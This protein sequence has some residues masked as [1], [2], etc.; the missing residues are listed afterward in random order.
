M[1]DDLLSQ[2]STWTE[3]FKPKIFH[4]VNKPLV[5]ASPY[6]TILSLTPKEKELNLNAMITY[7]KPSTLQ[8]IRTNYKQISLNL[9]GNIGQSGPCSKC[10]LCGN[11]AN[12]KNMV[13]TTS[14]F[15]NKAGR[16]FHLKQRLDCTNFGIYAAR[17]RICA[18]FYVGQTKSRFSVRWS[19]HRTSW[20]S[21][22]LENQDKAA[23]L[24]HFK[25]KHNNFIDFNTK[26]YECYEVIF[27]QEPP[28]DKLDYFE[29]I[30]VS[31]LNAKI[32]IAKTSL[33]KIK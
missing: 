7:K 2:A 21:H 33:P 25:S 32:N 26:I 24:I 12:H 5:W 16:L 8:T 23:L 14:S 30:W 13:V 9:W 17:C 3:R 18:E 4:Q 20:R 15:S 28:V 10:A 19:G 27:L 31:N 22:C 29:S 11:F 6:S 1:V